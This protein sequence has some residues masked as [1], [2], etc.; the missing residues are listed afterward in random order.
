VQLLESVIA[1][2]EQL[3]PG[4]RILEVLDALEEVLVIALLG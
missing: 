2:L 4:D 1:E 3:L